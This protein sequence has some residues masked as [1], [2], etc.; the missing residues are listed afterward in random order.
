[1]HKT[2]STMGVNRQRG[3]GKV[4]NP[5]LSMASARSETVPCHTNT[6]GKVR[7]LGHTQ[8]NSRTVRDLLVANWNRTR[9][10]C[11]RVWVGQG[12]EHSISFETI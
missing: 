5:H 3:Q 4:T 7:S 12:V 9:S 1:M 10:A 2:L 6:Y 11:P 8:S